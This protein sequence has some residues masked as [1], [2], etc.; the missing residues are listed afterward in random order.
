VSNLSLE[1]PMHSTARKLNLFRSGTRMA[2]LLVAKAT[3]P[4]LS[5]RPGHPWRFSNGECGGF[6]LA[7]LRAPDR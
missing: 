1:I 5:T 2:L 6:A 3:R 4:V 7:H